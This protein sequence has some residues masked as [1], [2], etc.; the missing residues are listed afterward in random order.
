MFLEI[1]E[2]YVSTHVFSN[3]DDE[4]LLC[5]GYG[6]LSFSS[7]SLLKLIYVS[8]YWMLYYIVGEKKIII[9]DSG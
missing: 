5:Y 1:Q 6:A 3:Y 2:Y 4:Y 8:M 7:N 9:L